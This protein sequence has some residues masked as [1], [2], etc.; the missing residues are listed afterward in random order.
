MNAQPIGA[1]VKHVATTRPP[2][3][4]RL[5]TALGEALDMLAEHGIE[6]ANLLAVLG[7][8]EARFASIRRAEL[9]ACP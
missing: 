3:E 7:D 5:A 1:F 9:G 4:Y 8:A 2:L 6:P